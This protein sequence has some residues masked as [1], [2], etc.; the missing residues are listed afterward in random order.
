[1]SLHQK[2][3]HLSYSILP[4]RCVLCEMLTQNHLDL[5][6]DCKKS[7]LNYK[8]TCFQCGRELPD[9]KIPAD[10]SEH[11]R[12][13]CGNCLKSPPYFDK[14]YAPFR[15]VGGM[16]YL[17]QQLKFYNQT[18][19]AYVLSH[20]FSEFIIKQY[21]DNDFPDC[22]IPVPLHQRRLCERGFNQSIEIGQFIASRL[23]CPFYTKKLIRKKATQP[24]FELSIHARKKNVSHAFHLKQNIHLPHIALIDDIIT[25]GSTVNEISRLLKSQGVEKISVWCLARA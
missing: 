3:I 25:T 1:M 24:Q 5:C 4:A 8:N 7:F 14:V 2:L 23:K 21:P 6:K 20:C 17:I 12:M 9:N 10:A 18:Q 22:L 19:I 15:Y 13:L 16:K 11:A